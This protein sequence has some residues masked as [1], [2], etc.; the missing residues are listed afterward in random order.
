[1]LYARALEVFREKNKNKKCNKLDALLL[2]GLYARA[3]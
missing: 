2:S 3:L 1:M